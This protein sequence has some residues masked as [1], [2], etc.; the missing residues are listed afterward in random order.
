M[1][2]A[3]KRVDG[4]VGVRLRLTPTYAVRGDI[5]AAAAKAGL[6]SLTIYEEK[7]GNTLYWLSGMKSLRIKK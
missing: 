7:T 1:L 2:S 3:C 6:N 4:Y 5:A